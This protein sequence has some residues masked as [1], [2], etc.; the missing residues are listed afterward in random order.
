METDLDARLSVAGA[1][2]IA[3]QQMNTNEKNAF[4]ASC[5]SQR[6][7]LQ[8]L[9]AW[10]FRHLMASQQMILTN[11]GLPEFNGPTIDGTSIY[12]QT[13]I[14]SFLHSAFFIRNK[15]GEDAH[16]NMLKSQEVRLRDQSPTA[17]PMPIPSQNQ[18]YNYVQ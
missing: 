2:A 1:A 16:I 15:I 18:Q 6:Q 8:A 11:A 4:I 7:H 10:E 5:N 17:M 14:C 9:I 3:V 13:A 12:K